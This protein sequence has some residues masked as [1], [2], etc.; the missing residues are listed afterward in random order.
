M[1][2]IFLRIYYNYISIITMI[3]YIYIYASIFLVNSGVA[4]IEIQNPIYTCK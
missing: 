4:I 1:N 2:I 3:I